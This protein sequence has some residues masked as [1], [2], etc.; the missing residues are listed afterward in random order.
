MSARRWPAVAAAALAV[1][2]ALLGYGAWRAHTHADVWLQVKDHAGRTPQR[3]WRE[4]IEARLE[5]CDAQGR[6]LAEATLE[7]P[8]GLPRYSG[9]PGA[10]VDCHAAQ[11]PAWH[12][13]W[14]RQSRWLAQWAPAV[15]DARV[16]IGACVI[17][18]VPV[19]RRVDG[20]WWLWWLPLPHVGGTPMNHYAI[21][22]HVDSARCAAA[23]PPT[24]P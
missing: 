3:L 24:D 5:L 10:V 4:V 2:A 14:Q 21:D 18:R 13:C 1:A 22:L 23:A 16:E 6:S 11:G 17:E 19:V 9:P 8:H 20:D 15:A 7:P 12:D